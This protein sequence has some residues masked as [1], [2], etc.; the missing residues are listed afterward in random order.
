MEVEDVP[1]NNSERQFDQRDGDAE[2]DGNDARDEHDRGED[3]CE[4]DR[5]H[6]DLL[7]R[8]YGRSVEAISPMVGRLGASLIALP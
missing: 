7:L 6:V 4:F 8:V 2:L 1:S 3:C 5:A